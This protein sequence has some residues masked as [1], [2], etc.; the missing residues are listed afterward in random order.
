MPEST[1]EGFPVARSEGLLVEEVG[2]EVVV[3]DVD[4]HEA[5]C[6]N[7]LAGAVFASSD[8]HTSIGELAKLASE[9]LDEPVSV[10]QV[11]HALDELERC[12]LATVPRVDGLSRRSFVRKTAVAGAVAVAVPMVTSIVTPAAAQT[13]SC[14]VGAACND[15]T[16]CPDFMISGA[17]SNANTCKCTHG[18]CVLK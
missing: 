13:Q 3:Y 2:S 11:E 4:R 1:K 16:D 12:E 10:E 5:H 9:R 18:T 17:P 8:G 15:K 14:R 6:L 7:P